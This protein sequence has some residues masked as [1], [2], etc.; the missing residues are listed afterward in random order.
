[1]ALAA[2]SKVLYG[3]AELAVAIEGSPKVPSI[4]DSYS[5][6]L[7]RQ[8][9][10]KKHQNPG[11]MLNPVRYEPRQA[12]CPKSHHAGLAT[13]SSTLHSTEWRHWI[14]MAETHSVNEA[15]GLNYCESLMTA[16]SATT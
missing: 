8:P 7:E 13:P 3:D 6:V 9:S 2:I 10:K 4:L 12:S 1:M 15:R 14:L 11:R 16:I 5:S